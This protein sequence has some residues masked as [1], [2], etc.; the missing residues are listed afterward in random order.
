MKRRKK[1]DEDGAW[2]GRD[3]EGRNGNGGEVRRREEATV[4]EGR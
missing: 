4:S 1:R 2:I 3:E